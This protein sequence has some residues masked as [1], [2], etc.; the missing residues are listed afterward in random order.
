MT[1]PDA[2]PNPVDYRVDSIGA[3]RQGTNPDVLARMPTGW[4]VIGSNQHLPGYC[5]LIH[6]GTADHLSDLPRPARL[7]F[8]HDVILLGEAVEQA[9][10]TTD[11]AFWRINYEV[12]GNSWPHLHA[13]IH[14]RYLWEP[15]HLRTGPIHLYGPTRQ[16]PE[17]HLGPQH[18]P[19]RAAITQALKDRLAN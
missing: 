3:A 5:L 18:A 12:L 7:A 14:P 13:H 1:N 15:D 4:A 16:S 11:P 2:T 8:M 17:H 10:R 19:L 9:C 6:D